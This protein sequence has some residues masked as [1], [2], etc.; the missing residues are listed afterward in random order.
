MRNKVTHHNWAT[1]MADRS[2]EEYRMDACDVPAGVIDAEGY[3]RRL[4]NWVVELVSAL[5]AKI[6]SDGKAE[7]A[8]YDKHPGGMG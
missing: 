2:P 1:P 3:A 6:Q 7:Q 8:V 4:R 5:K